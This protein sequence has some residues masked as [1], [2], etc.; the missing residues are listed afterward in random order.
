MNAFTSANRMPPARVGQLI[1]IGLGVAL[2][3]SGILIALT[4]VLMGGACFLVG[5]FILLRSSNDARR[6]VIR[7]KQ[8]F[9]DSFRPFD[10]WRRRRRRRF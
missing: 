7:I 8:R 5:W 4:P 6:L 9:P 10:R 2:V 3:V 1:W